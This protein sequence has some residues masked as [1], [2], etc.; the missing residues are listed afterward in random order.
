MKSPGYP[1]TYPADMDC[2]YSVPIPPG[3][4]MGIYFVDFD[5]EFHSSCRQDSPLCHELNI[6]HFRQP[7]Q[8]LCVHYNYVLHASLAKWALS[9]IQ[10]NAD[11]VAEANFKALVQKIQGK[12]TSN[13]RIIRQENRP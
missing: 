10:T 3:G 4:P 5:V 2:E 13:L 12:L 6:F 8:E 7:V 9:K 1:S 11:V